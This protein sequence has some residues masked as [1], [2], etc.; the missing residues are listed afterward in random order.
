MPSERPKFKTATSHPTDAT[1]RPSSKEPAGRPPGGP[2]GQLVCMDLAQ[3]LRRQT[4]IL[5]RAVSQIGVEGI[6]LQRKI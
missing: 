1:W 4:V 6:H 2:I 5:V 3:N